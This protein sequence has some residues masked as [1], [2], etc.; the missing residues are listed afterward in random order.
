MLR[1]MVTAK[2]LIAPD[3]RENI[4]NAEIS[5][6]I[7]ESIMVLKECREPAVRAEGR[8]LPDRSSSLI[9]S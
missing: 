5:A 9:R 7:L 4:Q 2:P 6:V 3:P 1:I 8:L